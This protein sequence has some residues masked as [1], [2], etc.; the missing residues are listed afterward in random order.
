MAWSQM[1]VNTF[2]GNNEVTIVL[3]QDNR[4]Y[5]YGADNMMA[6]LNTGLGQLEFQVP[7]NRFYPTDS[8]KNMELFQSLL[9]N[10]TTRAPLS[11]TL[12]FQGEGI[13]LGDFEGQHMTLDGS[14]ALGT[15]SFN[16]PVQ[17]TGYYQD[18]TLLLDFITDISG[19][20]ASVIPFGIQTIK[21]S[22]EGVTIRNLTD[23]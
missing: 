6:R 17:V 11:L 19:D 8:S 21:L 9:G 13:E 22:G 1:G 12:D 15:L 18:N 3:Q 4:S 2:T 14:L 7:D 5:E 20:A 16:M 10:D 23:Q